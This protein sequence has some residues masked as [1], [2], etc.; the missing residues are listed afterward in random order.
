MKVKIKK[1]GVASKKKEYL[2]KGGKGFV[3]CLHVRL[4]QNS[5][6]FGS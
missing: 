6:L 2:K 5:F 3:N 4:P 1:S